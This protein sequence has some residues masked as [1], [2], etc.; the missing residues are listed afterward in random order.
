MHRRLGPFQVLGSD[1]GLATLG[2]VRGR[3]AVLLDVRRRREASAGPCE[4]IRPSPPM[5]GPDRGDGGFS[6]CAVRARVA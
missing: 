5:G 2:P 6:G 4:W 1:A 3:G